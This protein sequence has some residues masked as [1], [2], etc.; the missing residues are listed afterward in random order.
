M[1]R[2]DKPVT[3]SCDCTQAS[4]LWS[5]DVGG[6]TTKASSIMEWLP[7]P[8]AS[9]GSAAWK[10]RGST[11]KSAIKTM[12]C[13]TSTVTN[14]CASPN[15]GA[16]CWWAGKARKLTGVEDSDAKRPMQ[17]ASA[18]EV[19]A[20]QTARRTI[21]PQSDT[22]AN[23]AAAAARVLAASS[24]MENSS[25]RQ[26]ISRQTPSS[27]MLSTCTSSVMASQPPGPATAP[28]SKKPMTPG[29][30]PHATSKPPTVAAMVRS[31]R[32]RTKRMSSWRYDRSRAR[33]K[34]NE[35]SSGSINIT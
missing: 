28:P 23:R 33:D 5:R 20:K 34:M 6:G 25:P 13:V 27:A 12:S 8:T 35:L 18:T 17:R 15:L 14:T 7:R 9:T 2:N 29:M 10:I 24:A 26:K 4:Q 16:A 31:K 21:V 11:A 30:P 32:S 22:T 1:L 3:T 19:C